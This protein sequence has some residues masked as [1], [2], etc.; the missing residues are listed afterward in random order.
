LQRRKRLK[1]QAKMYGY[2]FT[3]PK[4]DIIVDILVIL[5]PYSGD[6]DPPDNMVILS[7]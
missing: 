7:A 3:I 5:T 6:I 2:F 4:A 1:E